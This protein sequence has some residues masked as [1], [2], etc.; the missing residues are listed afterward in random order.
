[1]SSCSKLFA[2]PRRL[3]PKKKK[4]KK[5]KNDQN[6]VASRTERSEQK[7]K[8]ATN[9]RI[10]H[11][12]CVHTLRAAF[13]KLVSLLCARRDLGATIREISKINNNTRNNG[14]AAEW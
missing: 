8:Q 12:L 5:K 14:A 6:T 11:T 2:K 9:V 3:S 7:K 4:K 1:M 10:I 13:S